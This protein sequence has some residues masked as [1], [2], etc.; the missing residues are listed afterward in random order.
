M[1]IS[2]F[3]N[4]IGLCPMKSKMHNLDEIKS[5]IRLGG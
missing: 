3:P 5:A 2:M 4:E 1:H